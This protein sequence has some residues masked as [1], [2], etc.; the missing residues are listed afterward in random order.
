MK[1]SNPVGG[2]DVSSPAVSADDRAAA[3]R[4]GRLLWPVERLAAKALDVRRDIVTLLA[5]SQTGHS[6]G[7]L[8][9][10]DFCTALFFSEL[11]LDPSNPQWPERDFWHFSIGH[12]TP[13]IYSEMAERGYFPL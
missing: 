6:G 8:S 5:Q 1:T 2:C 10:A 3:R 13:V 11:S 7:P 12:V 9:C 4:P